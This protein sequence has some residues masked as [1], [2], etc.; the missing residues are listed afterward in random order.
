[1]NSVI[2]C[3]ALMACMPSANAQSWPVE[4]S[5]KEPC[6]VAVSLENVL[7]FHA[8]R[9]DPGALANELRVHDADGTEIPYAIR[10]RMFRAVRTSNEWHAL[11]LTRVHETNG[12]LVVE[13][14]VSDDIARFRF[15]AIKVKTPLR[16]FET[17]VRISAD[18][19]T[20]AEGTFCDYSRFAD[21]RVVEMPFAASFR[22][23]LVFTFSRPVSEAEAAKFERTITENSNGML[24]AK[25]IRRAVVDRPFRID[26]LYAA[27]PVESASFEPAPPD[28]SDFSGEPV[29]DAKKRK[30]I[31]E[32]DTCFIPVTK[33]QLNVSNENFSRSV[34]VMRRVQ[35]G[36]RQIAEGRI[37]A[38][39][40]P[41]E[42][43]KSLTVPLNG[44]FRDEALRIEVDDMDNPPLAY[45]RHPITL[46]TAAQDIVFIAS[47]GQTYSISL[48]KG[49]S[50]PRYDTKLLDYA[51]HAQSPARLRMKFPETNAVGAIGGKSGPTSIWLA[52]N[53]N[54]IHV[55][56]IVVF[57]IL[58]VVCVRLFRET[59][60]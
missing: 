38:V 43:S 49:R 20:L 18:G 40:L 42:K 3:A 53:V 56:S 48:E 17:N 23:K 10:K 51:I 27:I 57:I 39:N 41:G 9:G 2:L 15:S 55:A 31:F 52:L 16:D 19:V 11:S 34:R 35:A 59:R 44:E 50:T 26:A 32:L 13:A 37:C 8:T 30:T 1:M 25:T 14:H 7:H 33:V 22:R 47:P 5:V 54:P 6:A 45:E 12:T 58:A 28:E 29:F 24:T 46:H 21:V 4:G 60:R 36:W